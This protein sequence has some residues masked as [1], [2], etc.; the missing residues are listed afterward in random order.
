MADKELEELVDAGAAADT[1][2]VGISRDCAVTERRGS[3]P[4]TKRRT[5]SNT[6]EE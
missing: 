3:G 2:E 5:A 1:M 6:F 4:T